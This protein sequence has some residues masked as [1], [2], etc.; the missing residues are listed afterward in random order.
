MK[1]LLSGFLIGD[2]TPTNI[3]FKPLLSLGFRLY[4]AYVFFM[5]GL[6]KISSW[7][8]TVSLFE[9]EYNVPFIPPE[10][11]AYMATAGELILPVLL[12]FGLLS[13]PA[14]LALFILNAVAAYA[15]SQ[16]DFASAAG[17]WQHISWGIMLAVIFA[18]GPG[19]LSIDKWISDKWKNG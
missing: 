8:S 12:V 10:I 18:F 16:T 2:C 7:S 5:S 17:H 1:K 19:A 13:R 3:I 4:V 11:A 6:T 9:Y 15:L 14:A